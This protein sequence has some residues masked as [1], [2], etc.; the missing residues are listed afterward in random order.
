MPD[1]EPF[2]KPLPP[3]LLTGKKE[4]SRNSSD[5]H[6]SY[7]TKNVANKCGGIRKSSG[8]DQD[9]FSDQNQTVAPTFTDADSAS[10][11]DTAVLAEVRTDREVIRPRD[12]PPNVDVFGFH[13]AAGLCVTWSETQQVLR[14]PQPPHPQV[15]TDEGVPDGDYSDDSLF[16]REMERRNR[17]K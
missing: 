3:G 10:D 11:S 1:L 17:R 13:K 12:E 5:L 2:K 16:A 7:P 9:G 15:V 6:F 4:G 14:A 8:S